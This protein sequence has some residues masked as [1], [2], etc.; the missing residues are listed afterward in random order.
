MKFLHLIWSNL[1]RKK[2]RTTLTLLSI[3]VAF[4]LF[5]LLSAVKQALVGGVSLAGADRLVVRHRVSIIQFLPQTYQ[6]RIERIPGV[7]SAVHQTW[8]GGIYQDQRNFFPQS[9]VVPEEFLAMYP[10]YV[11]P[12]EAKKAWL[13]TRT[14]AIVGRKTAERF[15]WKVGDRVP[16]QSSIWAKKDR[17]RLWEFDVVGIFDG[18][19]K[20]TDTTWLFFRYDYF[21]EA[22]AGAQGSVGWYIIRVND[23][24]QAVA[25]A[26]RVDEEFA[27]SSA[28]TKTETEGAFVQAWARQVGDIAFITAAILSAVFFT[29][30]L[31]AGNTMAQA[32]RERTGEL[33]VLKA[34]GFTNAQVLALVLAESCLLAIAGGAVGLGLAWLAIS[35]GDP[36][37]GLLPMFF[38][39]THDL[40]L[41]LAISVLLGLAT[42]LFP[43]L[44]AMRLRVADALRR[45]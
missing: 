33:G 42:G 12:P 38:F 24:A 27:N 23:P 44:Q 25:V 4:V 16:I 17:S 40:L 22:R 8:F 11:L 3:L 37:H 34:V 13:A 7:V 21:D 43:A 45:M 5:G 29:I 35:R 9:P 6:A 15:G 20:G 36:T 39:P 28:E 32:V 10:E 19:E 41:G 18:K 30:L 2:L 31:V 26:R 1:K 14:G